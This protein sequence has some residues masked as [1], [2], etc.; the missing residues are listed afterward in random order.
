LVKI[1]GDILTMPQTGTLSIVKKTDGEY[2]FY[3]KSHPLRDLVLDYRIDKYTQKTHTKTVTETNESGQTVVYER[4]EIGYDVD[5]FLEYSEIDKL[6]DNIEKELS[7]MDNNVPSVYGQFM[8]NSFTYATTVIEED[9][10]NEA[11]VKLTEIL[12]DNTNN[13]ND[14]MFD[15]L[16]NKIDGSL[17][18]QEK[19]MIVDRFKAV[20]SYHPTLS[21]GF[22]NN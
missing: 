20:F 11:F 18:P 10:Y 14:N 21:D 9:N 13:F 1:D 19:V 15:N 2:N 3:Y 17:T 16:R 7:R 5:M 6:F 12:N 8:A 4:R 22:T